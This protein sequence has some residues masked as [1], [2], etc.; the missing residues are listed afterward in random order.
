MPRPLDASQRWHARRQ[1]SAGYRLRSGF[2]SVQCALLGAREVVGFD[3][4]QERIQQAN[5]IASIVGADNTQFR[6]LDFWD[7]RPE[8]LG[9]SFDVVLNLGV[10]YH[11]PKALE[12][13]ELTKAVAGSMSCWTP[14]SY[15]NR[16]THSS[17]VGGT[18]V[19]RNAATAGIAMTPS[20]PSV[21]LMLRHL[22]F[23]A[24]AEIP[25]RTVDMP[26]TTISRREP[27]VLVDTSLSV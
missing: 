4:G 14:S 24:W 11:L 7:M 10:L 22:H 12:A 25:L 27:G 2:W 23:T 15:Q 18:H 13:L 20:R 1:A 16:P 8:T 5:L 3:D 9:G 26:A 6:V 19:I 21:E 17:Q